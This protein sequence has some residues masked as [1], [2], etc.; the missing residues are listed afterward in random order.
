MKP[1]EPRSNFC[2]ILI[3]LNRVCSMLQFKRATLIV[4]T[5]FILSACMHSSAPQSGANTLQLSSRT[6][7]LAGPDT[8]GT[9]SAQLQCGCPFMFESITLSGDTSMICFNTQALTSQKSG[10]SVTV[11]VRRSLHRDR[12]SIHAAMSFVVNDRMM[13]ARCMDSIVVNYTP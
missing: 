2:K 4:L 5:S 13:N 8:V 11:T 9:V 7:A 1:F 3:F 10:H 6:L 12:T